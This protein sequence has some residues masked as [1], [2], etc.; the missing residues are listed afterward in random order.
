[1]D[2]CYHCIQSVI[3][4]QLFERCTVAWPIYCRNVC[5]TSIWLW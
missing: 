3:V 2:L 4:K 5:S 1:M